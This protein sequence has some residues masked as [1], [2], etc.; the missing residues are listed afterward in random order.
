MTAAV[1]VRELFRI[2]RTAEGDAAALQ[3]LTLRIEPGELVAVLGPSGAGKSTLLRILAALERPSAGSAMVLGHE[4]SGLRGRRATEFRSRLL[5]IVDQH[6]GR[7]L[8]PDLSCGRI[9]AQ[10][11]ALNGA[12]RRTCAARAEEL[13]ERVGL[14]GVAAARPAELSGGE[15]QRV[16][17]C[18]AVAHQPPLLLADEP[19]GELDA[20]SA[21]AVYG[22]IAEL[23]REHGTTVVMVSHDPATAGVADRSVQIRDGRL[24]DET[25][26]HGSAAIVVGRGGWLRVPEQLLRDA[27]IGG[28]AEAELSEE[29]V[30]LR[31]SGGLVESAAAPVDDQ[32]SGRDAPSGTAAELI[33]VHKAYGDGRRVRTVLD[34]LSQCFAAGCLTVV[35]GR[36]GSGKS[37][38]LRLLA[39]L[40]PVDEGRVVVLGEELGGR[41]RADLAAF[42]REHVAVVAQEPDLIGFLGATEN[43]TLS[44]SLR[45]VA[46][47]EAALRAARWLSRLD[48]EHR[49]DQR[50]ERLSAGERQRVAIAR[51]LAAETEL[52]LVDEPT[53]RLDQVNA[54]LVGRLLADAC[55]LHGATIVCST[56]E[57][58]V[59]E[60]ADDEVALEQ[61]VA[62]GTVVR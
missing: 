58:L 47:D 2:H 10:S 45:G 35:T 11:L 26:R 27:G 39:G 50:V 15:Q 9:V 60:S 48:L 57:P 56:H 43:I 33:G 7:A 19:G 16:A 31:P 22:L 23:A 21:H 61:P 4:V 24:S 13:L 34:G 14:A 36:S 46:H 41:S 12:D 42:R 52:V 3:G 44:L 32:R 38:V 62:A 28:R 5:G 37:T 53:S 6:Y 25:L 40:E 29:G 17:V 30:L 8:T 55:R 51:A 20:S 59:A 1:D 49:A 54:A 18:A